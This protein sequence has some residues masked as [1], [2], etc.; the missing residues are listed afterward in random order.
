MNKIKI[1]KYSL[2]YGWRTRQQRPN[3]GRIKTH[4]CIMNL[5]S[6][7]AICTECSCEEKPALLSCIFYFSPY[8]VV[9]VAWIYTSCDKLQQKSP[10]SSIFWPHSPFTPAVH[11]LSGF[12]PLYKGECFLGSGPSG[13]FDNF[14]RKNQQNVMTKQ[15]IGCQGDLRYRSQKTVWNALLFKET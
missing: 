11:S 10:F 4:L 9:P 7:G 13:V 12:G 1:K 3:K 8:P 5:S 14:V 15:I 2:S 6:T